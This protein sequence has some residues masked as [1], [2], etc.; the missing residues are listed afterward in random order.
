MNELTVID[1]PMPLMSLEDAAERRYSLVAF[2][3]R[4]MVKDIDYGT[5]PGTNKPTLLKP[6][7]EK[8]TT[9]F[10]LSPHYELVESEKDWTGEAHGGEPFFYF[11]YRC[12]LKRGDV[13]AGA[14]DGSCNSWEKKYRFRSVFEW[15]ATNEEKE[16][17]IEVVTKTKK[18]G[19]G[20][21]Q[22]YKVKNPNPADLV[23][24]IQKM[25]QKR[26][27]VAAT[28]VAVN[29]SEFFTQDM[30]DIVIDGEVTEGRSESKPPAK[31]VKRSNNATSNPPPPPPI[32]IIK[33]EPERVSKPV[34]ELTDL[35]MALYRNDLDKFKLILDDALY[36]KNLKHLQGAWKKLGYEAWPGGTKHDDCL[37]RV[38]MYRDAK[39]YA[40]LRSG[41]MDGDAAVDAIRQ[42][43]AVDEE[44]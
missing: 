24:T 2:T 22:V 44:E 35:E 43:I 40:Q 33:P 10:G 42:P 23:N 16:T 30:E 38:Q 13:V 27:L 6:G 19:H 25:A 28:L 11:S 4:I 17:A 5:I 14:G 31:N 7:A 37:K 15:E 9:F 1:S 36:Y 21:Y 32:E 18:S 12:I 8:L 3:Q 20:T 26:A 41:G 34:S 29:A 39:E